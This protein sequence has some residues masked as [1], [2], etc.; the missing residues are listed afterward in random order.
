M[1]ANPSATL[2]QLGILG[3]EGAAFIVLAG[4]FAAVWWRGREAGMRWLV[5]GFLLAAAW[6][7]VAGGMLST[8]PTIET[9]PERI[10]SVVIATAVLCV[11]AGVVRYLGLPAG[12]WRWAV[13][14][15]SAPGLVLMLGLLAGLD[16]SHRVF[17]V[18]VLMAYAGAAGLALRRATT[19]PGDGHV[20]LGLALLVQPAT[21]FVMLAAGVPPVQLKYFAGLSLA[22]FGMVLLTVSL[23]RRHRALAVEVGLRTA[24]EA[25]LRD[26][27]SRLEARV[28]ERTADLHE[29]IKGLEAFN[30]GVSHDLRGPLAGMSSL[31]R[32]AA[33][34]MERGDE[35]LA[36]RALP[37]I[38]RQCDVSVNLVSTLLDLARLG[39]TPVR[40]EAVNLHELAR[41]AFDEVMLGT[42][43]E[44]RPVLH[45]ADMP[46][47]QADSHLLRPV[48]VNLIANAVKFTRGQLAPRIE[49]EA[50]AE[51]PE[52]QGLSVYVRDNGVGFPPEEAER[53]FEPLV[54][55]HAATHE[56][57]GLGLSIVRRAVEAMGGQVWA[58]SSQG[59]GASLCFRLPAALPAKALSQA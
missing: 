38:A 37:T 26:A 13:L 24:A 7:L 51:G 14:A 58:T 49:V 9:W 52:G 16:V 42:P 53:I 48:F 47:V 44:G 56:G 50:F 10:W 19:A 39:D 17:H 15:C 8:G 55:V 20:V 25:Q 41:S 29:L 2:P 54:R 43:E 35:S 11:S 31:A 45:C 28:Q 27:N 33:E 59:G 32:M 21:P 18:G 34:G 3:F 36:R 46:L 1:L 57:H 23:L 5:L 12:P 6:Y 30:R 22:I 4:L 40:R